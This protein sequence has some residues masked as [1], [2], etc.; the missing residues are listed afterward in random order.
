MSA[1]QLAALEADMAKIASS[2]LEPTDRT[3]DLG[4]LLKGN[5]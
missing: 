5:A 2:H 4:S 1:E 3:I